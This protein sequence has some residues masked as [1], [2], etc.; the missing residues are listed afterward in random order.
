MAGLASTFPTLVDVV[1]RL[2]P[3][4]G[5]LQVAEVLNQFNPMLD[6]LAFVEGNLPTG[7]RLGLRTALPTPVWRRLNQGIDPQVSKSDTTDE[8]IGMLENYSKIDVD[9]AEINGNTAAFRFSEDKA[10]IQ[11]FNI[12]LAQ[13]LLYETQTTAPER[14]TGLTPRLNSTSNNDSNNSHTPGFANQ[15]VKADAAAAGANQTSIWLVGW[16]PESVFGIYPKGSVGGLKTQDLGQQLV[17]DQ[18]NKQFLAYVTRFQWKVGLAVKDYRY[19][20]RVCNIDTVNWKADLTAGA[21][22]ALS[23]QDGL[24][25]IFSTAGVKLAWYMNRP[26]YAMLNKQLVK[27]QANWLEWITGP[28]G[29]RI[30]S[31]FGQPIRISDALTT[32]ESVVS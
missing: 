25:R 22:L 5:I 9:M 3:R 13:S 14:F 16:G 27:R 1:K 29:E 12:Q 8:P 10:F 11:G 15:F 26:T 17:L 4:G 19:L 20:S 21:D 28:R 30:P 32:S 23:M 18:N 24:A 7:H 6:D 31:Y 2:D